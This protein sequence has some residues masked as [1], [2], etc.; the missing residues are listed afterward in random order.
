MCDSG[1]E[2]YEQGLKEESAGNYNEAFRLF[3]VAASLDNVMAQYHLG[4]CHAEGRGTPRNRDLA[5]Q[6][7]RD[8]AS[9]GCVE[10]QNALENIEGPMAHPGFRCCDQLPGGGSGEI[11]VR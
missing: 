1:Q 4:L 6:I 7:L 2:E 3:N 9:R 5:I 10:A 11:R 8:A